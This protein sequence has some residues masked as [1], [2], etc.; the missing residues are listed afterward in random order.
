MASWAII[1]SLILVALVAV[2]AA[3]WLRR[4]AGPRMAAAAPAIPLEAAAMTAA[5]SRA[6]GLLSQGEC[7]C[8]PK[9]R[10][11][12]GPDYYTRS[13][14]SPDGLLT[15]QSSNAVPES[16]LKVA[17][18]LL[19]GMVSPQLAAAMAPYKG[20]LRIAVV[21][22]SE[23]VSDLPEYC[24]LK[25]ACAFDG[26]CYTAMRNIGSVDP[27]VPTVMSE[28]EILC[29]PDSP[30][31]QE[32]I[33]VHEFAHT[34]MDVV[35]KQQLPD[36]YA[37]IAPAY[38]NALAS[39]AIPAGLYISANVHEYWANIVAAYFNASARTDVN[40][41]INTYASLK[42]RDPTGYKIVHKVFRGAPGLQCGPNSLGH[43]CC[44]AS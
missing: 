40:A 17:A 37:R 11:C 1:L 24:W 38:D 27:S 8:T 4:R 25:T 43:H 13:Y 3:V 31:Y 12:S 21:A 32:S 14:Q 26:R 35:L 6:A 28:K 41:G 15:F 33:P 19:A 29:A 36:V 18:R 22:D 20:G 16:T 42:E 39:G 44:E 9:R 34:I 2:G 30:Y 7:N 5:R 23:E 10:E